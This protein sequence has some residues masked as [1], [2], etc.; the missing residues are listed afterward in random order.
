[1]LCA[2]ATAEEDEALAQ[3]PSQKAEAAS[4]APGTH[5]AGAARGPAVRWRALAHATSG[6]AQKPAAWNGARAALNSQ[7][8]LARATDSEQCWLH[9][10]ASPGRRVVTTT[11][12]SRTM[13]LEARP[14]EQQSRPLG[15]EM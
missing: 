1:M 12:L 6:A 10:Q 5:P 15:P 4:Q 13:T 3:R 8:S 14:A 11:E 2:V 7:P 9:T